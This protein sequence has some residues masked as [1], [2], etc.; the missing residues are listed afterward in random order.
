MKRIWISMV[1]LIA[2]GV[3]AQQ[4]DPPQSGTPAMLKAFNGNEAAVFLQN[5][6]D[7]KVTFQPRRSTRTMTVPA[8]KI[9]SL[10]FF[11]KYDAVAVE[12]QFNSGDYS[13]AIVALVE[14]MKPY[15]AYMIIENN[16]RS[17]YSMLM[18]AYR[19]TGDF[20]KAAK[21]ASVM[22]KTGDPLLVER[23]R[24]NM[25]LMALETGDLE[26]VEKIRGELTS[27]AANLYLKACIERKQ[28]DPKQAIK[29][30]SNIIINHDNDIEWLGP[31]ELL[32]AYLYLDMVSTNSVIST[33]SAL[34][35]ARQVK[36]IYSGSSV[37]A[38][39]EK[40]WISLGGAEREAAVAA[41]KAE[42]KRIEAE[43][44]EQRKL[45]REKKAA[46][47]KA[48]KE[49]EQEAEAGDEAGTN[50]TASATM[51]DTGTNVNTNV[52]MES[53]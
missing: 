22:L 50:V 27:V 48:A 53:E 10:T 44:E 49:A 17:A 25:A 37:A 19:K 14:V 41:E 28:G 15:E 3:T 2:F 12:N 13:G 16:M 36:N 21:I 8:S 46:E 5:L 26:T 33:N 51:E 30:V 20:S 32:C 34:Y 6:S 42:L 24:V 35:T 40:L 43:E 18:E 4:N 38:D 31:S 11:P 7:G 47:E 1:A 9:K 23:G 52:E 45:E 29:T 39:A